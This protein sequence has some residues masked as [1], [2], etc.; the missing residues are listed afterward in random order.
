M[1]TFW[2]DLRYGAQML[3]KRPGFTSNSR[4]NR[5]VIPMRRCLTPRWRRGFMIKVNSLA[6]S[7]KSWGGEGPQN[8]ARVCAPANPRPGHVS[9]RQYLARQC[10]IFSLRDF[11]VF[12]FDRMSANLLEAC[13]CNLT[14]QMKTK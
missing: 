7:S 2:Q 11:F 8:S 10:L 14:L 12:I 1:H 4:V 9:I 6:L 5:L 13:C 3:W